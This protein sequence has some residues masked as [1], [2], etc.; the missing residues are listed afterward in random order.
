[1]TRAT[2]A[3]AKQPLSPERI[4]LAA[5]ALIERD[6]L[7]TFSTRKLA[8]E[9]H[10]EAMSIYHYFPSKGHLMDALV[11]RVM[12]AEMSVLEA[13]GWDWRRRIEGV[14]RELRALAHRRPHFF[15]YLA[16][17]R[18]NT[19]KAL[20]G[21][22]GI[23]GVFAN[24]GIGEEAGVRMFR[25]VS[26]YLMGAL[27]DETAGYSRGASTVE[28]IPDDVMNAEF[29]HVVAAG[30]WFRATH[31][32]ATFELGLKVMLDGVERMVE[33]AGNR[34]AATSSAG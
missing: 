29:P 27:L 24:L 4:E 15:G 18:M 26:Y 1:M 30:K 16:T 19:P 13:T 25:A 8:A 10:C 2:V 14:A 12:G 5:L 31:W 22:D 28:P 21:L 32:E 6:S 3:A 34:V 9:L 7:A 23:I 33:E 11:D 20:R 17:H